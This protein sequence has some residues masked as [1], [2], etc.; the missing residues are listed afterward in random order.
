[1]NNKANNFL[2]GKGAVNGKNGKN[3]DVFNIAA[4]LLEKGLTPENINGNGFEL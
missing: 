2:K 3:G 1:M 4:K